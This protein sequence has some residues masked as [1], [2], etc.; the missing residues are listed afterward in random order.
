MRMRRI[1]V[2]FTPHFFRIMDQKGYLIDTV[3]VSKMSEE[4]IREV[5][6]QWTEDLIGKSEKMGD[7]HDGMRNTKINSRP[8]H[9]KQSHRLGTSYQR[10]KEKI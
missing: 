3:H 6:R 8:T 1:E 5:G 7:V 2:P 9:A 4:E 10:S